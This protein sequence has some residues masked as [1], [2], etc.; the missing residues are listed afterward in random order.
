MTTD[1]I[2]R[3]ASAIYAAGGR[4]LNTSSPA[5][6]LS[7]QNILKNKK[8]VTKGDKIMT[9]RNRTKR[10]AVDHNKNILIIGLNKLPCTFND[11]LI[12]TEESSSVTKPYAM[13][14]RN[15]DK[16]VLSDEMANV[17]QSLKNSAIVQ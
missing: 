11:V 14:A 4:G 6:S 3:R 10:K 8:A 15:S 12:K 9:T 17:H 7:P 13:S 16:K 5:G 2:A 1:N